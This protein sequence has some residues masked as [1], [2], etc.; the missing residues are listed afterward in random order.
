MANRPLLTE[1]HNIFN[2]VRELLAGNKNLLN[3]IDDVYEDEVLFE[4]K[5]IPE[6]L[7][8]II[9]D[10]ISAVK[11]IVKNM[12]FVSIHHGLYSILGNRFVNMRTNYSIFNI[13]VTVVDNLSIDNKD[14]CRVK[15]IVTKYKPLISCVDY[16]I[17]NPYTL[18]ENVARLQ[19]SMSNN[20]DIL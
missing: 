1:I 6:S 7:D 8:N 14:K 11:V 10:S 18:S 12:D 3:N 16:L 19:R 2:I 5:L 15:N 13:F 20:V 9:L 4:T 17:N